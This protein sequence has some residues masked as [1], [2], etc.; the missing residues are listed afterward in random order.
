MKVQISHAAPDGEF[1]ER[2]ANR[3]WDLR[4]E[5]R[6]DYLRAPEAVRNHAWLDRELQKYDFIIPVLSPSYM[7]DEWLQTELLQS[8]FRE[9]TEKTTFVVPVLVEDC[10]VPVAFRRLLDRAID[11]RNVEFEE[12]FTRLAPSLSG[13]RQVFVVMKFGDPRLDSMYSLVIK[14]VVEKFGYSALRIDEVQSSG[15]I[16]DEILKFIERSAIVLADLT[17]ERPNC[18]YE[19]GYAHALGKELILSIRAASTIPFDLAGRR[20]IIWDTEKE[21]RDAL[22][23]RLK[24]IAEKEAG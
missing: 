14:P 5:P 20:F 4:M 7:Q 8:L 24:A 16:T 23:L 10:D 2:L 12:A 11:F 22:E 15:S 9:R 1:V 6:R 13:P 21:L 18:Y 19:A 3:L 17:D